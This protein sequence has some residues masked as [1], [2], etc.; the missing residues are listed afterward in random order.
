MAFIF[1]RNRKLYMLHRGD[2]INI[3]VPFEENTEDYYNGYQPSEIRERPFTDR[4]GKSSKRRMVVYIGRD[5]DMVYYLTLTSKTGRYKDKEHQY[6]L[7]DNS[8]MPGYDGTRN[9]SFVEVDSVRTVRVPMEKLIPFTGTLGKEDSEN[10]FHRI[11]R[12]TLQFDSKRDQRG[13][14][15]PDV[16]DQFEETLQAHGYM[17]KEGTGDHKVF[18]QDGTTKTITQTKDGLVHYHVPLSK[19]TVWRLVSRRE[20]KGIGPA[21]VTENGQA[22][23][24]QQELGKVFSEI[25]NSLSTSQ[26]GRKPTYVNT[27]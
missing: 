6:E 23:Q 26:K 18:I 7:K 9:K 19:Q 3:E 8:M 17:Q 22:P 14:I 5:D 15:S 11:S 13:W 27:C 1:G 10:I 12:N 2:I 20:G 16:Q 24:T 25:I 4:F 21:P